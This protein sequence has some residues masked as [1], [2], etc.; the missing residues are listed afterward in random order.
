MVVWIRLKATVK[1]IHDQS[2]NKSS[3]PR[4]RYR[5]IKKVKIPMHVILQPL[6]GQRISIFNSRKPQVLEKLLQSIQIRFIDRAISQATVFPR[7]IP[8]NMGSAKM[9]VTQAWWH[10]RE[11]NKIKMPYWWRKTPV[12]YD[13]AI[14]QTVTRI[15]I[16][17]PLSH[18]LNTTDH[19]FLGQVMLVK[20][21]RPRHRVTE[22][23]NNKVVFSIR[24]KRIIQEILQ[25]L[26]NN[27]I[28]VSQTF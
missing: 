26:A 11:L 12:Q 8:I 16:G 20:L 27:K 18:N 13:L 17:I 25:F 4:E 5:I 7:T 6:Q 15:Q 19:M 2:W 14:A 10:N 22:L 24:N 23:W 9:L 21:I 3:G 28:K 1:L